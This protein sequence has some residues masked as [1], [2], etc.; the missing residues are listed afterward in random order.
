MNSNV[1]YL[2]PKADLTVKLANL[3][4]FPFDCSVGVSLDVNG[5]SRFNALREI[6][7]KKTVR[8]F[9]AGF[10]FSMDI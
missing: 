1:K 5:G 10:I 3:L 6:M 4:W 7:D 9:S 2:N 8:R